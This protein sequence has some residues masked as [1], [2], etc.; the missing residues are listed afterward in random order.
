MT[1]AS[2]KVIQNQF[3]IAPEKRLAAVL[4]AINSE[5]KSILLAT[6]LDDVTFRNRAE[7]GAE[8]RKWANWPGTGTLKGYAQTTLV[9]IGL[10]AEE[11]MTVQL[12]PLSIQVGWRLS[13]EGAR[14][15][16]PAAAYAIRT[17]LDHSLSLYRI[18]SN[19]NSV[20]PDSRSPG[21]TAKILKLL[22]KDV[23]QTGEL[24]GQAGIAEH[25]VIGHLDRLHK[26]GLVNLATVGAGTGWAK[27]RWIEG[28]DPNKAPPYIVGN[29]A[30]QTRSRRVANELARRNTANVHE[31]ASA[32]GYRSPHNL[33]QVL[34]RFVDYGYAERVCFIG[35]KKQS[36]VELTDKGKAIVAFVHT[37]ED[38][39]SDGPAL[40]SL[41]QSVAELTPALAQRAAEL[42]FAASSR[43]KARPA[44]E[45]NRRIVAFTKEY[46]QA[47]GK[48][49]RPI[50]MARSLN[51]RSINTYLRPMLNAG[52]LA[53]EFNGKEVR[54]RVVQG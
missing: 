2:S 54:Y 44:E 21:N 15:A 37:L 40:Q 17:A 10:V 7:L 1:N 53:K 36:D 38:A 18:F 30:Y 28:K 50:D 26:A 51:H 42:Y 52:I 41:T 22:D 46:Q 33:I 9:P 35:G 19:T 48:G 13:P 23:D 24:A 20:S 4:S 32:L 49:P 5:T 43:T 47:H 3:P 31:I 16:R 27:Y 8:Y 34:S 25:D 29:V 45:W 11:E 6:S 39:L 12:Q 14:Y